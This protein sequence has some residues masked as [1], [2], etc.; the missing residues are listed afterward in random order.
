VL[1]IVDQLRAGQTPTHARLGIT[2]SDQGS[3]TDPTE[4]GLITGAGVEEVSP[5]SA[6]EE[7]GLEA[8]DV[9]TKVD[10]EPISSSESLVATIRGYRPGDKVVLT[11]L[12]DGET[13]RLDATLDSDVES[14]SS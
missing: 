11:V 8:G 6:G 2:V 5:G 3:S 10:D 1:P 13:L 14:A 4:N 12:R 7:A 9:V